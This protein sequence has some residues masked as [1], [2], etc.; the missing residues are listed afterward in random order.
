MKR[1][2]ADVILIFVAMVWGM[3]F[4]AQRF[5][6][7]LA[8]I[9]WF[10]GSRF[11][12]AG[13][14][15]LPWALRK[16]LPMKWGQFGLVILTSLVLAGASGL[17]QAGLQLT[18]A[19][20]AG[21]I[22]SLYVILVPLLNLMIFGRKT[23]RSV[24]LAASIAVIGAL[25]LSL[26]GGGIRFMLGDLLEFLGAV[27]WASHLIL[28]DRVVKE[29][30]VVLFAVIQYMIAGVIQTALGAMFEPGNFALLAH[31]WWAVAY[32]GIVSVGIGYTLQ[33]LAQKAAPPAD[34]AII[35]SMESVFAALGGYIF[36][37]ESLQPLQT[38]GCI[39]I[40]SAVLITQIP[41]NRKKRFQ[42][43]QVSS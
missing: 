27:L 42:E 41:A 26:G 33:A 28:I 40:F 2:Q 35:L 25:L 24:W 19:A 20:N 14:A 21:F 15:L 17:Q 3:A 39:I 18:T 13:L 34:A 36:L 37:G 22:T 30:D 8:G 9:W 31:V 29:V 38:L 7:P 1:F 5:A 32:T 12:L 10:N 16:R 11:L 4:A 6:A 43:G 23:K